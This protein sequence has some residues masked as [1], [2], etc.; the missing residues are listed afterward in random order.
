MRY[1]TIAV[2]F[3]VVAIVVAHLLAPASYSWHDNTISQLAAQGYE[4]VWI[5]RVGFPGFGALIYAV[6]FLWLVYIEW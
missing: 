4:R 2:A 6:G 5:M 3:I 1:N